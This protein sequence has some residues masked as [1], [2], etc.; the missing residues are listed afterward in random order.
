MRHEADGSVVP[1]V[2]L[3]HLAGDWNELVV[4]GRGNVYVNGRCEFDFSGGDP[5][6]IIA[7]VSPDGSVRQV[8]DRIAFPN[9][10]VVTPD[11]ATLIVSESFAGSLTAC[12]RAGARGRL[13]VT[14]SNNA[15]GFAC[16]HAV[17]LARHSTSTASPVRPRG[18]SHVE[19]ERKEV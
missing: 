5:V 6:G 3:G 19:D 16:G 9:G 8:A 1:H 2:D 11:N 10:M 13:A 17:R 7:L 12:R 18:C 15:R 14:A 4:D